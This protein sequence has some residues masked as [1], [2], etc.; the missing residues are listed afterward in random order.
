MKPWVSVAAIGGLVW[1]T[2]SFLPESG[3]PPMSDVGDQAVAAAQDPIDPAG[4]AFTFCRV[5]YRQVR[6][7][8]NGQGWRTDYPDADRNLMLRL[9]QLTTTPIRRT[10]YDEPDH[11]IIQFSD[12]ELF[13][14]PFIFMSDVG[15]MALDDVEAE[16]LR[17]Y[18]MRGGFLWV[19]DFWGDRAWAAWVREIEKALPAA[20]YPIR[21]IPS[22]HLILSALYNV[23]GVPQIP[24]I[25]YW[26][27]SGRSGTS[28]RGYETAVPHLRG[29]EDDAGRVIVVMTHNTDIA[30]GWERGGEDEDFFF[31]FSP[32]AYA[33]GI[34]IVLYAL[35]H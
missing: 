34:N 24:S 28:E 17:E 22:D 25:Q 20:E 2:S 11:I 1:S 10:S 4:R 19:D 27:R 23:Y 26:R 9:S 32:K 8:R 16:R 6:R 15:T 29:I 30:D 35:T 13:E 14:C 18:L 12:D 7:E 21:D 33:L 31:E 3:T 5:A